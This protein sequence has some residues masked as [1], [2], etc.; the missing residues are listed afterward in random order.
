MTR[1]LIVL[2][3]SLSFVACKKD[4]KGDKTN[5]GAT[6][7]E[8]ITGTWTLTEAFNPWTQQDESATAGVYKELEFQASGTLIMRDTDNNDTANETWELNADNPNELITVA[9]GWYSYSVNCDSLILDS[10]PVD[11]PRYS[12]VRQ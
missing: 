8:K 5:C 3:M 4:N 11:G 10:T 12:Y 1:F 2:L 7:T 6:N 9:G